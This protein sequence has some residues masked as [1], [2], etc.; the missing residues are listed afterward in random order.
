M[1]EAKPVKAVPTIDLFGFNT[2]AK[3][4]L[5]KKNRDERRKSIRSQ[6]ARSK[7]K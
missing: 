2:V 7:M 1:S 4:A 5:N 3:S 6:N